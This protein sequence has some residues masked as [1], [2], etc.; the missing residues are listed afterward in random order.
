MSLFDDLIAMSL[1]A[2]TSVKE[3]SDFYN[4]A[5]TSGR[6]G[7]EGLGDMS[8]LGGGETIE[9]CKVILAT[10]VTETEGFIF[11]AESFQNK[12]AAYRSRLM[13]D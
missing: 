7:M 3:M 12:L 4:E 5:L 1:H 9:E 6:E 10:M 8:A 13:G 11:L 2:E